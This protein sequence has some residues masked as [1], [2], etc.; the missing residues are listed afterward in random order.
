M[1]RNKEFDPAH[2]LAEAMHL[3]WEKGYHETSVRDLVAHTGVSHA[4]LYDTF[5]NK[6]ELFVKALDHY[7]DAVMSRL[8]EALEAPD[9]SLAAIEN[10]FESLIAM[11][12]SKQAQIGCLI[13][14]TASELAHEDAEI[15]GKIHG[16]IAQ[17]T[18][19]F[20]Q[21]LARAKELGEVRADLDVEGAAEFL[22]ATQM[23]MALFV[24]ARWD[25]E[26]IARFARHAVRTLK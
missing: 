6:H 21:D 8:T 1:G 19:A 3:F 23:S 20:A 5:G 7:H 13:C 14:T 15:A 9:A 10:H 25:L 4:G 24:R 2:A 12:D 17:L 11:G 18:K 26:R 16:Y 22:A